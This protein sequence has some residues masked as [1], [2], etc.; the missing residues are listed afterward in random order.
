MIDNSQKMPRS[1]CWLNAAQFGGAFNDNVFRLLVVLFLITLGGEEDASRINALVGAIFVLPF[2]LF[3]PVAGVLASRL[4]K[5]HIAVGVKVAEVAAMVLAVLA[6]YQERVWMAYAVV[7]LMSTQSAIF[8]PS[9]YG[10]VPELVGRD[11]LSRANSLLVLFTYLAIILGT[12]AAPFMDTLTDSHYPAT[13]WACLWIA[14]AGLGAALKVEVT[15]IMNGDDAVRPVFIRELFRTWRQIRG[16]RKLRIAIAAAAYFLFLGGFIQMNI[17]PYGIQVFGLSK[18]HSTY[19]F[20]PAAMGIG[21]GAWLVGKWSGRNIK[22]HFVPIGI[23]GVIIGSL[24]LHLAS[25]QVPIVA[26][27]M[28]GLGLSAGFFIVPLEAYIQDQSPDRQR[29]EVLALKAFLAWSGVLAAAVLLMVFDKLGLTPSQGFAAVGVLSMVMLIS[30]S[31]LWMTSSPWL[32]VSGE[33]NR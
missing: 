9:K 1:F 19:L 26:V 3:T 17:I 7:F 18:Q 10:I 22:L 16:Q 4:S 21:L 5:R 11:R 28:F 15:P 8:G 13:A 27:I 14:L 25:I 2:L 24:A 32:R 20:L 12:A 23:T 29:G 6:F 31:S 30:S 33:S